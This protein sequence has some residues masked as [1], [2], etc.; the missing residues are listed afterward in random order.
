MPPL[1]QAPWETQSPTL[2]AEESP[3]V[4]D[5]QTPE[6]RETKAQS[7]NW[8]AIRQHLDS[9]IVRMRTKRFGHWTYAGQIAEFMVP[10]RWHYF[11][12]PNRTY[13][14]GIRSQSILDDTAGLAGQICASGL[15]SYMTNPSHKWLNVGIDLDDELVPQEWKE[16]LAEETD[17]LLADLSKS[18]FYSASAQV[19][20]DFVFMGTS[21]IITYSNDDTVFTFY[22]VSPG[23]EFIEVGSTFK[24]EVLAREFVLTT[25]Q[26]VEMFK[27]K[28]CPQ[29][30]RDA[31]RN[32]GAEL[33]KEWKVYHL[34][35]PN[36][37]IQAKEGGEPIQIVP[38]VF[39]YREVYWLRDSTAAALTMTGFHENPM[40]C[41]RWSKFTQEPYA[42]TCPGMR[43]LGDVKQLQ[44]ETMRKAHAIEMLVRPPMGADVSLNNGP[45][46]ITP[47]ATTYMTTEGGTVKKFWP[48]YEVQA[49]AVAVV[50]ADIK[51]VQQRIERH[52]FV[53]MFQ[54]LS[55]REGVQPLNE[56][57]IAKRDLERL[58]PI[59]PVISLV[60]EEFITPTINR[61]IDI[62]IRKGRS[63]PMPQGMNRA[64]LKIGYVGVLQLAQKASQ[65]VDI[66]Q[67]LEFMGKMSE[68]A[69][70]ATG[71]G[72]ATVP[73]P[74]RI[75]DLDAM[76][77]GYMRL[78]NMDP[79]YVRSPQ[80][81]EQMD[82]AHAQAKQ[83]AQAPAQVAAAAQVGSTLANTPT[84]PGTLLHA[85]TGGKLPGASGAQASP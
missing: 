36:F 49:N 3:T 76:T 57:E 82:A 85:I 31:W 33:Y 78:A 5:A 7:N 11:V 46:S 19:M 4:P 63:R 59:A 16:W 84:G 47:G 50:T 55:M 25:S 73:D 77:R 56:M 30:V 70:A 12:T 10:D 13:R 67:A 81:V 68:A 8:Q 45:A 38:A 74:L 27:L 26:L 43:A 22:V 79:T 29:Q 48:L 58:Q 61:C 15:W 32:A 44:I 9:S 83:Q 69:I 75:M 17:G 62:R 24:V 51:E 34:I 20:S 40:A 42:P 52:F 80:Q 2:L 72:Q 37:P 6:A 71:S 21:P 54:A 66:S 65:V 14:G 18:N 60:Y 39:P 28:N 35:E 1:D 41:A 64:L 53:P 23:E